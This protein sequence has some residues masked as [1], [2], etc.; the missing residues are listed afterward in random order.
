[1]LSQ[2]LFVQLAPTTNAVPAS[3]PAIRAEITA[4]PNIY[5]PSD[6]FGRFFTVTAVPQAAERARTRM[7]SRFKAGR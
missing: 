4:D 2:S 3:R 7:W 1:M 5:P 6:A